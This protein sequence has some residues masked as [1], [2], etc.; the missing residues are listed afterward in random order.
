MSSESSELRINKLN[1][2][3]YIPDKEFF[4]GDKYRR[5]RLIFKI[6][7]I[8][9][10]EPDFLRFFSKNLFTVKEVFVPQFHIEVFT[11]RRLPIDPNAIPEMPHELISSLG[12]KF[13]AGKFETNNSVIILES[14]MPEVE[15][16]AHLEITNVNA[17]ISNISNTGKQ[18]NKSPCIIDAS[19]KLMG[20]GKLEIKLSYNLLAENLDFSYEGSSDE[21]QLDILNSHLEVEDKTHIKSGKITKA[22]F[23]ANVNNGFSKVNLIPLYKNL[24]IEVLEEES[25]ED[26]WLPTLLADI[27]IRESNPDEDGNI[28]SA[29]VTYTKK[30]TDTFMDVI[31][32]GILQGI[33]EVVGF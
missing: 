29:N 22:N 6:P 3:P 20:E 28:K 7:E 13:E 33:G 1:L 26:L 23:S 17:S 10:I 16:R 24:K 4:E 18:S 30:P 27:K 31:W 21:M 8:K 2:Q 11:N 25:I 12:F 15:R 19:G 14:V 5:D 9:L 32:L